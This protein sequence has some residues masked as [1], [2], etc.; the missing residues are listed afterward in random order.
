MVKG[1]SIYHADKAHLHLKL[2]YFFRPQPHYKK[3]SSTRDPSLK[4]ALA[5]PFTSNHLGLPKTTFYLDCS[6]FIYYALWFTLC[7]H[8]QSSK[9]KKKKQQKQLAIYS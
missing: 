5:I 8:S 4:W 9:K 7:A 3:I 2:F 6:N 1:V